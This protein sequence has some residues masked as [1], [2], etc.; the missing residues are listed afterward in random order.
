M[1]K[2]FGTFEETFK[3]RVSRYY[4]RRREVSKPTIEEKMLKGVKDRDREV[5]MYFNG[6]LPS[7][8][9]L[10]NGRRAG[11]GIQISR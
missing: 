2:Y 4:E 8:C 1:L 9:L 11:P 6:A 5:Q 3:V 7:M 10:K